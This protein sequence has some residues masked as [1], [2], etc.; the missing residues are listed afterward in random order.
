M[1]KILR[2]LVYFI[3]AGVPVLFGAVEP[4]VWSW[5]AFLMFVAFVVL[6]MDERALLWTPGRFFWPS[7]GV[8]LLWTLLQCLQ[9]PDGLLG[10]FSPHQEEMRRSAQGLLDAPFGWAS[11]SYRPMDSFAGWAWLLGLLVFFPVLLRFMVQGRSFMVLVWVLLGVGTL[12]AFYGLSQALI[13]GIGVLWSDTPGYEGIAR[14]T[15]IN[16]NH[17][18]FL[19]EMIWPIGLG[20]ALSL[21]EWE[22]K[23]GLKAILSEEQINYQ[24]LYLL[25][26]ALM[27]L[28]LLF[29]RSRGGIMGA[30]VGLFVFLAIIRRGTRA[31]GWGYW[32]LVGSILSLV[33][34]YGAQIGF[35]KIV[36]RFLQ[37]E[38]GEKGRMEIWAG[39]WPIVRDH[40]WGTGLGTYALLEPAYVEAPPGRMNW[41]AHNDYLQVLVETGWIGAVALVAGYLV[42]LWR[43]LVRIGPEVFKRDRFR[44]FVSAGALAGLFSAAFH[45]FFDFN[46]QIPANA[47]Y[48]VVLLALVYSNVWLLAARR[49]DRGEG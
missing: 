28:A 43:S 12:E 14:G 7:A 34:V 26:A 20:V 1:G 38:S 49:R 2:G 18:A 9:L 16:R 47:V 15:L 3:V 6:L 30:F 41:H 35:D 33:A 31:R 45:S 36:E 32:V 37:M 22:G 46:L 40:V 44:F 29:T 13:P 39:T 5:Y 23:K 27:L 11:V 8:F 19:L 48:L 17:Y 42:F 4:W 10:V 25:M 21:G 24:L